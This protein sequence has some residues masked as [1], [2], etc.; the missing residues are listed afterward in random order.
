MLTDLKRVDFDSIHEQAIGA[1][2]CDIGTV[3]RI[4]TEFKL[5][6][7]KDMELERWAEWL[8]SV[9]DSVMK[10]YKETDVYAEKA[11]LFLLKWSFYW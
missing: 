5:A 3:K 11:H 4:E 10:P 2:Q 1:C 8:E 9:L 6:M 7:N